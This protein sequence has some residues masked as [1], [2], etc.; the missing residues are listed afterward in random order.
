M[1]QFDG[2][3]AALFDAIDCRG[4]ELDDLRR[5][6]AA[7]RPAPVIVLLTFPRIED[8][9]RIL[10]AGAAALISKPLV[11]DELYWRIENAK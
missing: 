1:P 7:V 11:L 8:R 9:D 4:E 5:L 10:A 2:V 6:I 3:R